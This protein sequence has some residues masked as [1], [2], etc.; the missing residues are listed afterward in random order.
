MTFANLLFYAIWATIV[1]QGVV[2]GEVFPSRRGLHTQAKETSI[3]L[4]NKNSWTRSMIGSVM[5]SCTINECRGCKYKCRAELVPVEGND[6]INSAYHYRCVCHRKATSTCLCVLILDVPACNLCLK[7]P[8][9]ESSDIDPDVLSPLLPVV[10]D[11][12]FFAGRV[13]PAG[14]VRTSGPKILE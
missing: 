7:S 12:V 10:S 11:L 14:R 8:D 13:L 6:P 2:S 9:T 5:P 1:L 3:E 4:M